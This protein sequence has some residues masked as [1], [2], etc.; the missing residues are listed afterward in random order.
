MISELFLAVN[1]ARVGINFD[2]QNHATIIWSKEDKERITCN[3]GETA[4]KVGKI[5]EP[6]HKFFSLL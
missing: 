2:E 6:R 3:K 5:F 1:E 4:K